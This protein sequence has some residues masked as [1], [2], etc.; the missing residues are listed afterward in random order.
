LI[1]GLV[2]WWI[3]LVDLSLIEEEI[4]PSRQ[5]VSPDL[6]F[7]LISRDPYGGWQVD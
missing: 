2:G 4:F 1:F 7:T 5:E 6:G 3:F